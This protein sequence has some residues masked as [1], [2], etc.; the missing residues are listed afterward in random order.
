MTKA[1]EAAPSRRKVVE[2]EIIPLVEER[3]R[4]DKISKQ[5][6]TVTVRT[7]PVTETVT[8]SEPVI[9]ESVSVERVPIGR[10]VTE[11]PPV[12]EEDDLTVIPVVE[13]QVRV[14]VEQVLVE[15]IHLRRTREETV[16]EFEVERRR[17]EVEIDE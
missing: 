12:R 10:V 5:G 8:V 7:H 6:R 16:E 14:V 17:T 1:D 9:R 4:F 15:E 11:I 13:E 3:V 2:E